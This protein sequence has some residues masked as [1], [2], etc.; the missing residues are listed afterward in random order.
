[1]EE[2]EDALGHELLDY[3]EG[4]EVHEII[5]RDDGLIDVS[6]GPAAYFSQYEDWYKHERIAIEF[7]QGRILDIGCGAGRH[8]LFLQGKGY[9]VVAIDNSPG[10]IKVCRRRGVHDARVMSITELSKKIGYFNTILM[11]GNNFGL[12]GNARRARWLFRRFKNMTHEDGRMIV[13]STNTNAKVPPEHAAYRQQ[14]ILKGRMPG[15]LRIRVRYRRYK[16]PWFDYLLVSPEE[17][18]EIVA[19]TGWE[20]ERIIMPEDRYYAAI[21]RK[22]KL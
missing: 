21:I 12:M 9:E 19:G 14:N 18:G 11:M 2:I 4:K 20:V 6:P 7:A 10:A 15:Q 1:M 22:V 8:T 3:L 17:L 13:T 5:E 16:S